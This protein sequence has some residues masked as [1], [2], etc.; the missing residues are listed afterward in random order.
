MPKFHKQQYIW[1]AVSEVKDSSNQLDN[2]IYCLNDNMYT[3]DQS[4]EMEVAK[5]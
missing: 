5:K 4:T 1:K 2:P 3:A